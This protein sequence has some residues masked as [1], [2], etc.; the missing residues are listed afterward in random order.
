MR[1]LTLGFSRGVVGLS[2]DS[3]AN[4]GTR[5]DS[6]DFTSSSS[7]SSRVAQAAVVYSSLVELSVAHAVHLPLD[8]FPLTQGSFTHLSSTMYNFHTWTL[9][10]RDGY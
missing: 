1:Y 2:P 7:V 9:I 6:S 4:S 3:A 8:V 5:E 10:I